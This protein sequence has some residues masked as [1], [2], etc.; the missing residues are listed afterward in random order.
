M[1]SVRERCSCGAELEITDAA[2]PNALASLTAWRKKHVCRPEDK[3]IQA[4][5]GGSAEIQRFIGF[6]SGLEIPARERDTE[7]EEE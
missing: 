1:P 7:P 2:L 6:T 4:V 5:H 3:E